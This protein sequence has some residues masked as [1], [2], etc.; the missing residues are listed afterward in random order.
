MWRDDAHLLDMVI[1][2]RKVLR[3]ASGIGAE[4]FRQDEILQDAIVRNLQILG[5]AARKISDDFRQAHTEIPWSQ[6]IGMRNRLV[7]EYFRIDVERVWETVADDL[8]PLLLALEPLVP[9]EDV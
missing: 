5:E 1:A 3:Y 2:A 6:I 8:P 7:H 9:P 4:R